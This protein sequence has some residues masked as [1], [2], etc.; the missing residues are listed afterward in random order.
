MVTIYLFFFLFLCYKYIGEFMRELFLVFL[1][2]LPVYLVGRYI[3]NKDS[4]KEPK[5]LLI[6]LFLSGIGAFFVTIIITLVL[7]LFFPSLLSE[8]MNFDLVEL[9]FHV[10]F[11]IALVE[12]F[13]KWIF[14]YKIGFNNKEFDQVYDMIVYAVFVA[15]GFAC[16]ENIF[17]VLENGF[18]TAVVRGLLAVPGHACDGVFM[19]YYLSM[20]MLSSIH[21]NDSLR[22]RNLF[23]SIFVPMLLHGFYDYCLFSQNVLLILLFFVF[24][25]SLYVIT[26]KR[27]NKV[28]SIRGNIKYRNKFCGNCGRHVDSDFCPNCGSR[29]E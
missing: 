18:V 26:S 8:S 17:Y 23:L 20:A 11:G 3:Y 25:I 19:G 6:K 10:F 7:S 29:N 2:I 16:F 15:L 24:I 14:V 13:S 1:S 22:K 28:S 4:V 9:F 12:E 21:S 27:T 5:S